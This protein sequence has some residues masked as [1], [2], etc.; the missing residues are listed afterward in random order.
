M[1]NQLLILLFSCWIAHAAAFPEARSIT[2]PGS[3]SVKVAGGRTD[4]AQQVRSYLERELRSLR[5]VSVEEAVA[6]RY[7][8]FELSVVVLELRTEF[9]NTHTGYAISYVLEERILQEEKCYILNHGLR[10]CPR[11][12]L[13]QDCEELV[14]SLDQ[15]DLAPELK[16]FPPSEMKAK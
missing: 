10:T 6:G 12:K 16:H 7:T 13:R 3:I 8:F 9:G 1:K 2:K 14:A 4:V 11:E 15:N 5:T